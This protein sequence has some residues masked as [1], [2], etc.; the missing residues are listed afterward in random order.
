MEDYYEEACAADEGCRHWKLHLLGVSMIDRIN[1]TS[2]VQSA[3]SVSDCSSL[4]CLAVSMYATR[5]VAMAQMAYHR[6]TW[7]RVS[8]ILSNSG[9]RTRRVM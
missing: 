2:C 6:F 4:R 9:W 1:Q 3:W 5:V 8:S 7:K